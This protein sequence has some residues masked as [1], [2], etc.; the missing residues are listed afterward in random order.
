MFYR[1][2]TM[3][4]GNTALV[5]ARLQ[6]ELL[7]VRHAA[8]LVEFF[9][10]NLEHLRLWSPP[11]PV[12]LTEPSYWVSRAQAEAADPQRRRWLLFAPAESERVLGCMSLSGIE[13]GPFCSG[14]LGYELD[15]RAQ[16]RGLMH[17]ALSAVI[18]HAFDTLNLHRLEANHRPEN[19]RSARVLA[20]LGITRV[21][22]AP[23]YLF[24]DGAWRDH[25]LN[26]L[27]N[28]RFD[29]AVFG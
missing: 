4:D 26:Q 9:Q 28:P 6:L 16:G 3:N 1:R 18:G 8:A 2:G 25:V 22:L 23:S 20:R 19:L 11:L 14:R 29:V 10:R 27:L 15:Q 24:I 21:G 13:R 12:G 7:A 5:T 17:E